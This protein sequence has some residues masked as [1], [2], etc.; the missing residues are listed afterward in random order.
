VASGRSI[1]DAGL[2]GRTVLVDFWDYTCVNLVAHPGRE[3][4]RLE[5]L[6]DGHPLEREDAGEDMIFEDGRS[7]VIVDQPRMYMLVNNREFDTHDLSISMASGGIEL[8]AFTFV[9]CVAENAEKGR[10]QAG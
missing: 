2:R 3:P 5:I 7:V 9:T 4:G 1:D 10:A 8:Y 6:Q